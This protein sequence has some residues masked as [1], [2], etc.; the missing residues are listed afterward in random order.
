MPS[1]LRIHVHSSL[2]PID[3]DAWNHLV[4]EAPPFLEYGFLRALEEGRCLDP[5]SGWQ[6]TI[7]TAHQ[8]DALVGAIPLYE[9]TNSEGEFV[10]DW[11]WADAAHRA[12]IPYYPKGVAAV[13]F[14]PVSGPRLLVSPD[15]TDIRATKQ[16]LLEAALDVASRRQ[17]SSL[18]FN[19]IDR[20]EVPLFA[21]M[22]LPIRLGLQYHWHNRDGQ[23]DRCQDFDDF[24]GRFR[25]K[26]RSSIR[27]ERRRLRQ[28]DVRTTVLRGDAITAHHMDL[29]YQFYRHTVVHHVFGRQYLSHDFFSEVWERLRDRLH[30]VLISQGDDDPF[31]GAFNLIKGDRLYGRYWGALDDVDFAHFETCIYRPVEWAIDQGLKAFEP[32]AGGDHKFD[33]GFLPRLTYSA[34][35]IAHPAL[36]RAVEQ[37]LEVERRD[38]LARQRELMDQSP[39]KSTHQSP[40]SP[41]PIDLDD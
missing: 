23:G 40:P 2:V 27:R 4:A 25:S 6:A 9:T 33:R 19:F 15:V 28:A 7:V 34:H 36:A 13:P 37:F 21:D 14:T 39:F 12:G 5:S 11:A 26:K 20:H 38:V 10:F 8:G 32:G 41:P 3:R 29:A 31:G 22:G 24:L 35:H 16:A 30:L 17:W 18:H 1:S